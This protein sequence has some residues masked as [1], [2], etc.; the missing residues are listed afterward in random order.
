MPSNTDIRPTRLEYLRTK[1]RIKIAKKGLKLLKLKRQALIL[2]FF[3]I[4]KASS[5]LRGRAKRRADQGLPKHKD[6][7]DD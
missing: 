2:E 5:R 6:G 4:S 1:K 3:S 7:G